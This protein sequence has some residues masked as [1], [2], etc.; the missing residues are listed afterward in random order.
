[1]LTAGTKLV[2]LS[3]NLG[4][5]RL[6]HNGGLKH[7]ASPELPPPLEGRSGLQWRETSVGAAGSLEVSSS[8][9]R[10]GSHVDEQ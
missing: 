10:R 9:G 6:I 8:Q 3:P 4:V 7:L 1:M 2:G 5:S